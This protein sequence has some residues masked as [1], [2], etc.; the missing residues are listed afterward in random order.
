MR[1]N[2]LFSAIAIKTL[3]SVDIVGLNSHQH[4]INGVS[5]L[6]SFFSTA[7]AFS[8]EISW[9]YFTENNDKYNYTGQITFYDARRR[10]FA[11]TGRTEWRLYYSGDFM[12]TA[13][14]GDYL[15]LIKTK[16]DTFKGIVIQEH[17]SWLAPILSIFNISRENLSNSFF[18]VTD[19]LLLDE[20]SF[21]EQ[22]FLEAIEI[23]INIPIEPT[24]S[25]IAE[26]ELERARSTGSNFPSTRRL[27]ELARIIVDN[28]I[29]NPDDLL[30]SLIEVETNLFYA[31]ENIVVGDR[32]NL[33]FTS[34]REFIRFSLSV[35]N[36]RKSRMGLS[37][38][39]HLSSVLITKNI[40]FDSQ[41]TTEGKN[42]P[43][44]IFPS[45]LAY[46]NLEFP[47]EYLTILA[48]KSTCKERWRQILTEANRITIKH[49]CTLDQ[50]LSIDQIEEM[51]TQNVH[52]VIP[53]S[54]ANMYDDQLRARMTSVTNFIEAIKEKQEYINE[55]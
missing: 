13:S 32:L 44:F 6:R 49:L 15:F 28:S 8:D 31:I 17:S 5:A 46:R 9:Y 14:P 50:L 29:T 3:S 19:T 42:T 23:E 37:L 33:H 35:Q 30:I 39:N 55:Y 40:R 22:Q 38:Q 2:Q 34:V 4:E 48:A 36:R 51:T 26:E 24:Y 10:S 43:D 1:L 21:S 20:V 11:R 52:L 12:E 25:N 27:A 16:D 54:I 41:K 47:S 7:V 53:N 45:I 18:L